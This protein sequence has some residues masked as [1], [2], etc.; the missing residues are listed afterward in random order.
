MDANSAFWADLLGGH[1]K[2]G[3]RG[4][5]KTGQLQAASQ[6]NLFYLSCGRTAS[7]FTQEKFYRRRSGANVMERLPQL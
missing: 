1:P 3:S 6:D 2:P 7:F 4:H 5:L